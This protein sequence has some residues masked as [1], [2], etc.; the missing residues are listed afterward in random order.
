MPFAVAVRKT[1]PSSAIAAITT[2]AARQP[3]A[4]PTGVVGH[5]SPIAPVMSTAPA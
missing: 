5:Q 4:A 3:E 1:E 2:A